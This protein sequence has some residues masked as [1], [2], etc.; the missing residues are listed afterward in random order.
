MGEHFREEFF[1]DI[2]CPNY[3]NCLDRAA[4]S[5]LDLN[6]GSCKKSNADDGE[7]IVSSSD[8][9]VCRRSAFVVFYPEAKKRPQG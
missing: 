4:K 6:C 9:D 5:D 2:Y 8:V 7:L 1:R 3:D